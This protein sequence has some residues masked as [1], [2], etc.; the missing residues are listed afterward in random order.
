MR[1]FLTLVLKLC[2]S[3]LTLVTAHLVAARHR[4]WAHPNDSSNAWSPHNRVW[5]FLLNLHS[6][7]LQ[8]SLTTRGYGLAQSL[9]SS[10]QLHP[11]CARHIWAHNKYQGS[12]ASALDEWF[13]YWGLDAGLP[14]LS[15]PHLS[16]NMLFGFSSPY[17]DR[18]I[19]DRRELVVKEE[20]RKRWT[21]LVLVATLWGCRFADA[22]EDER[23]LRRDW[24][25]KK[26]ADEGWE[27]GQACRRQF[28][29]SRNER[30]GCR[31]RG[32]Q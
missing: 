14:W 12:A 26:R 22:G 15:Y 17:I 30:L 11:T 2:L 25:F 19:Q 21:V 24:G 20:N 29:Q 10:S 8:M 23:S 1:R 3:N 9:F 16:I 27:I 6:Q 7:H 28:L 5:E 31:Q 32:G 4:W 13:E 18:E